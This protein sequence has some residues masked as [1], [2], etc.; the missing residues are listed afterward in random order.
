MLTYVINLFEDISN[1]SL[2][3]LL[4]ALSASGENLRFNLDEL[5]DFSGNNVAWIGIAQK[6]MITDARSKV[7]V[8]QTAP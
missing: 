3:Y 6:D 2:K 7:T 1:R 8:Q 5:E 4:A